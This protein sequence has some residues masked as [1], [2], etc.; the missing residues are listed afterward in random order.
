MLV[1]TKKKDKASV[2]HINII[3]GGIGIIPIGVILR[4]LV[5]NSGCLQNLTI[6]TNYV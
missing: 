1:A 6:I 4:P 5:N 2:L 3:L